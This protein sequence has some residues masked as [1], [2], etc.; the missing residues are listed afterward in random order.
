VGDGAEYSREDRMK[1]EALRWGVVAVSVIVI[2]FLFVRVVS[3]GN[4]VQRLR[5]KNDRDL[6]ALDD[7]LKRV[8]ADLAA[9]KESVPGLGEYMTTIQLHA[10]KLWF[11]AKIS[12]WEL[13]QYELDELKETM[14]AAKGLNAEKNGVKISGVLDSVLQA[15]VA[16]LAESI[17]RKSSAEFQKSYDETLSACNGC[18][19]EAGYKFIHIVRPSSPPVTNQRWEMS[20]K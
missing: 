5:D 14:E 19:A 9:A 8:Q 20:A 11:A 12:N 13:A 10:G 3:L 4:E 18:H 17:K 7:S 2:L 15:Q 6:V 1:Y 16:Q